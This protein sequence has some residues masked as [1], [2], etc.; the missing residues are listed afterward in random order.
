M[1]LEDTVIATESQIVEMYGENN[2]FT[3]YSNLINGGLL[4]LTVKTFATERGRAFLHWVTWIYISGSI[5]R[6]RNSNSFVP[7]V[8]ANSGFLEQLY[9]EY[10]SNMGMEFRIRNAK[11]G[12]LSGRLE[13]PSG[14]GS[15][16]RLMGI[17]GV[18]IPRKNSSRIATKPSYDLQLPH[19]FMDIAGAEPQ[20]LGEMK[21]KKE[22]LDILVRIIFKDRLRGGEKKAKTFYLDLRYR[23]S[24]KASRNYARS[25]VEFLR[26]AIPD[27]DNIGLFSYD[28]ITIYPNRP[29]KLFGARLKLSSDQIGYLSAKT[30]ILRISA[31]Y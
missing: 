23:T 28:D 5:S 15:F 4:P 6:I 17:M 10:L 27:P 22:I 1:A 2:S 26:T 9:E 21:E 7:V 13:T 8:C 30:N 14:N 29:K 16:G 19:Y 3:H 12:T 25:V 20:G 11:K 31:N 24:K 18:P